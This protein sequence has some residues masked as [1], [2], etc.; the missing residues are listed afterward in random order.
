MRRLLLSLFALL[1][2]AGCQEIRGPVWSI[3]GRRVAYTIY[4]PAAN[5]VFDTSIYYV[6][7]DD[8]TAE[9]QLIARNAA[10][11][12]WRED[13]A[14]LNY[15]GERDASGFYTKI[16]KQKVGAGEVATAVAT[17]L[18]LVNFQMSVDGTVAL[19]CS[20]SSA[21]LGSAMRLE[22][23]T[24]A[25]NKKTALNELGDVYSPALTPNGKMLAFAQKPAAALPLLVI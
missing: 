15:V 23:L 2:L 18:K 16:F 24:I 21:K 25:D 19:L 1:A 9:P 3:D 5:G 10:Y 12:Y 7:A 13:N 11:P 22:M 20:G 6:E 8:D 17:G 14:T 4:T